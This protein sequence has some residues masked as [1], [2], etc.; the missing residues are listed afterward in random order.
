MYQA[1]GFPG[2]LPR[3]DMNPDNALAAPQATLMTMIAQGIFSSDL[4]WEYIY[5]G[6][7]LGVVIIVID[8]LLRTNTKNLC[9]PPLAV[10]IGIYLPPSL[11]TPLIV[12]AVMGY[13]LERATKTNEQEAAKH[14]GTLFASGLI[15][16]E[17]LIGVVI[18]AIIAASISGGGTDSPLALVGDDFASTAEFLGVAVFAATLAVFYKIVRGKNF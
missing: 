3:P 8:S 13:F 16:G 4:A 9:L 1:Y 2:A 5:F 7:G 18:A 15:V 11:Q 17:S 14:R 10:S 12:G 6:I